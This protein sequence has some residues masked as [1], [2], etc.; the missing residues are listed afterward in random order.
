M[1]EQRD[2]APLPVQNADNNQTLLAEHIRIVKAATPLPLLDMSKENLKMLKN[3]SPDAPDWIKHASAQ[4]RAEARHLVEE[5]I[6]AHTALNNLM[7]VIKTPH[8][9]AAPLLTQA[10][11][12]RCGLDL[13]VYEV[14]VDLSFESDFHTS[15]VSPTTLLEAALHNSRE[16]KRHVF[17]FTPQCYTQETDGTRK[18]I[19]LDV[20]TFITVCRSLDLGK[21]YQA[22]IQRALKWNEAQAKKQLS[23]LFINYQKAALKAVAFIALCK[24]D[25]QPKHHEALMSVINTNNEAHIDGKPVWYRGLSFN[26]RPLHSCIVFEI[27][28]PDDG[29]VL[30]DILPIF[31]DYDRN[32]FIAYIP[33][34]PAHP[35]KHYASIKEFKERLI[36]QFVNRQEADAPESPSAYQKFFSRFSKYRDRSAFFSSFVEEHLATV[37]GKPRFWDQPIRQQKQHPDFKLQL[38]AR[39]PSG[40]PWTQHFDLWAK[41]YE[42]F[43]LRT[44]Q[45]AGD[46]VVSNADADERDGQ[47][48]LGIFLEVGFATLNLLSFAIPPLGVVMLGISATQLM[49]EVVEGVVELSEGDKQAGWAHITDV[50]LNLGIAVATLP[51]FSAIHSEFVPIETLGGQKRLWKPDLTP[52]RSEVS[53][54]GL[55]PDALNQ[56]QIQGKHYVQVEGGVYERVNEPAT[57]RS[58]IHH[59]KRP[60]AYQPIIEQ[61]RAGEWQPVL[62]RPPK[63]APP[64]ARGFSNQDVRRMAVK[65]KE[66]AGLSPSSKGIYR[67][68]DGQRFYIRN[69]DAKG[70]IGVYRVRNDFNLGA[71]IVDVTIVDPHT[72]RTT[73]RRLW[74][75]A[76]DQW[77]P[78]SLRGGENAEVTTETEA[79]A[80]SSQ[81]KP[82]PEVPA[83]PVWIR[84]PFNR[85]RLPNGLWEPKI[86]VVA[87]KDVWVLS[88]EWGKIEY[89]PYSTRATY[90]HRA[91]S[92]PEFGT[93]S[94][95]GEL[96]NPLTGQYSRETRPF[97]IPS[98]LAHKQG[99]GEMMF[100][101]QRMTHSAAPGGEFNALKVVDLAAGELPGQ[102]DTVRGY[103]APQGGYVDIP[104]HPQ[105]AEPDHVF[106][107]SFSGCSLVVDQMDENVLRVRHV[108]GGKEA[109][110]YNDLPAHEHGWGLS[111]A[112]EYPDY[113]LLNDENGNAYMVLTG[114]AYLKYDREAGKWTLH[115]QSVRGAPVIARY[116]KSEPGWF[117]KPAREVKVF[118]REKVIKTDSKVVKTVAVSMG[119]RNADLAIPA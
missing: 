23:V 35:I 1:S 2:A 102:A 88:Y 65:V 61:D 119:H 8:D 60:Q 72:N 32:D 111:T 17:F 37:A 67:S 29:S 115:Y 25:I 100:S 3:C 57:G 74:Q 76:P 55:V 83:R 105:W 52:Y 46:V 18:N 107:P 84:P 45:D 90:I 92:A 24:G 70:K 62:K 112:M 63:A 82:V 108:E 71:E 51:V 64:Q 75:A 106:T 73:G 38:R 99:G 89:V 117:D 14:M 30:D 59:P 77:Q 95:S 21:Q 22:H 4:Q 104:V 56:Y 41:L 68:A 87:A 97:D 86:E 66:I 13:D 15:H 12:S 36:E 7:A 5:S 40:D 116:S 20:H 79:A 113:G 28:D 9:F 16:D 48:L 26:G 58:R 19:G 96:M 78:L 110:Q 114:F 69:I 49:E 98:Q 94:I 27:A 34:D 81:A 50:L 118:S 11:K 109:A 80:A 54:E 31:A 43:V 101:M 47:S 53:L 42:D 6:T 85:E 33:D 39:D 103:W 10:I 91:L 93:L 44:F